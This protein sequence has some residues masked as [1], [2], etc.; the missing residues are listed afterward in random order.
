MN[1]KVQVGRLL[2]RTSGKKRRC[3]V[4]ATLEGVVSGALNAHL[5]R[6]K[7]TQEAEYTQSSRADDL[8]SVSDTSSDFP[9]TSVHPPVSENKRLLLLFPLS[10]K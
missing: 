5:L 1:C 10:S 2:R 9:N 7:K 3:P 8:H 4:S 6:G